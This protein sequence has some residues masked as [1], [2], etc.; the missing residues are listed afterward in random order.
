MRGH[1]GFGLMAI[2]FSRLTFVFVVSVSNPN[3]FAIR[4]FLQLHLLW[5]SVNSSRKSVMRIV[6]DANKN[7]LKA[8]IFAIFESS[9]FVIGED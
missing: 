6:G 8:E 4:Y 7:N 5:R 9:R 3:L 1:A 2:R